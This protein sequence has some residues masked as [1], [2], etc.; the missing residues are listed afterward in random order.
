MGGAFMTLML[1]PFFAFAQTDVQAQIQALLQRVAELRQ[2]LASAQSGTTNTAAFGAPNVGTPNTGASFACPVFS[3]TLSRGA[4][5]NDVSELQKLLASGG[6]LKT[7]PTGYFGA[8]TE[9]ALQ[10]FQKKVGLISLGSP[11]TTG[12]GVFGPKSRAFIAKLC[13]NELTARTKPAVTTTAPAAC[14]VLTTPPQSA[15]VGI[16]QKIKD[17]NGCDTGWQCIVSRSATSGN[18][19][20]TIASIDG[21]SGLSVG[22]YGTWDVSA[23]DPEGGSLQYSAIWGDEGAGSIL[24]LLAGYGTPPFSSS[25][26][27]VHAFASAG[28][29]SPQIDVRDAVG[30]VTTG[31]LHITVASRASGTITVSAPPAAVSSCLFSGASYPEGT[32]TEGYNVN[33]LCLATGGT[34][35][36]RGAYIPTF[37][38]T[39]SAWHES[40]SNP[41]PNMPNYANFVG[42]ACSANGATMQALVSP[43]TQLCRS[44]LCAVAQN[45]APISLTCQYTN[46]VDWGIFYVGATTTTICVEPTSCEYGFGQGGRACAAKQDGKCP[47]PQTG[48]PLGT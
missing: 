28:D 7:E 31:S 12:W 26:R 19:P 46:W 3:R 37:T 11:E 30:N 34:C 14:T 45:Y 10:D 39:Q 27:L 36:N 41:Y 8:L 20:P 15:C 32:K 21:P 25:P 33:D 23:T 18:R 17:S 43:N 16:W 22:D 5:G 1:V 44:L 13:S 9:K 35:L 42:A 48:H 2:Q 24:E 29:Y 38:C 4:Q 40:Q 6:F 47:A